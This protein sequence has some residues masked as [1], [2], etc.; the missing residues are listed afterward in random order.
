M[1]A[2]IVR[3]PARTVA[4]ATVLVEANLFSRVSRVFRS[5]LNSIVTA[6]EDPEKI[7]D[8]A[9]ED[10][11][12]DLAK[13]RQG[14]AQV[15]A[16]KKKVE[17]MLADNETRSQQWY[18]KAEQALDK[19]FEDLAREA[20]Q[21]RKQYAD[22]AATLRTQLEQQSKA[23]DTILTNR[24]QLEAK[25]QEAILKKDTL[26]ARAQTAK[27]SRAIGDLVSGIN[28]TSAMAAFEKMEEK[29]MSMEAEAEATTMLAGG[30]DSELEARFALLEG[31][32][33]DNELSKMKAS[34]G[35]GSKGP[36]AA[37]PPGRPL[38]DAIDME[39][40]SMRRN[41]GS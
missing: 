18:Q 16:S 36:A 4:R 12:A 24:R 39:I 14:A 1:A 40:E 10:M 32:D 15:M 8:Q 27:S 5:Y 13:L 33:I 29:V 21:R 7:L 11:Q 30:Q 41:K 17:A 2:P 19:G 6:A 20:L 34:L 9:V 25:L 26:K 38:K 31:N 28:T 22:T 35:S 23:V 37:L 3:V